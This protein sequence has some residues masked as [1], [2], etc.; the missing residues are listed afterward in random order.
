MK[1]IESLVVK[2][3]LPSLQVDLIRD[4]FHLKEIEIE[5]DK[6]SEESKKL[7]VTSEDQ[8][9][10]MMRAKD[11][12]KAVGKIRINVEKTR[13]EL[14]DKSLREGRLI[15]GIANLLKERIEPIERH[16]KDQASFA[17]RM[18]AKR[19]EELI[20]RRKALLEAE[21]MGT[22]GLAF[23]L[24]TEE[25]FGQMLDMAKA[26]RVERE[27]KAE[28]EAR[29]HQV[30]ALM[31]E[32]EG[33]ITKYLPLG[34]MPEDDFQGLLERAKEAKAD[35][36]EA[37]RQKA[38]ADQARAEQAKADAA[39]K[40]EEARLKKLAEEAKA[41]Q[42][43]LEAEILAKRQQEEAEAKAKEEEARKLREG[44]EAERVELWIERMRATLDERPKVTSERLSVA[45]ENL[46]ENLEV[47]LYHLEALCNV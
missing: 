40:A 13:V 2:L 35:K 46:R 23:E 32:A 41:E 20:A 10:E 31:L 21:G 17:D 19:M 43:R 7:V 5:L 8:V 12:S 36:A 29:L 24:M 33:V 16:L 11:L 45:M 9:P 4:S 42:A 37:D 25:E 3:G 30:R 47:D 39:A 1:A 44:P 38:I 6:W 22:G 18:K 34:T 14:K 15:D 28:L 27:K 26:A